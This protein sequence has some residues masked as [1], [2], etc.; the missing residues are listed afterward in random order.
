MTLKLLTMVA[1]SLSLL[2]SRNSIFAYPPIFEILHVKKVIIIQ[3]CTVI[4]VFQ[5]LIGL[6]EK[7]LHFS[8]FV[9]IILEIMSLKRIGWGIWGSFCFIGTEN[10][11]SVI[12][13]IEYF[14]DSAI[15]CPDPLLYLPIFLTCVLFCFFGIF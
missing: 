6:A 8:A 12:F 9:L 2:S 15:F 4:Y 5:E 3:Q 11:D 7:K 13:I 10:S 1:L 14:Q